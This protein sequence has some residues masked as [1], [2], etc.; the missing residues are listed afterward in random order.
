MR[1]GQ[2]SGN[3]RIIASGD[4]FLFDPWEDLSINIENEEGLQIKVV[5][6]FANDEK[7][8][9]RVETAIVEDSLVMTCYNFD[10]LGT[11]LKRPTHI[12]DVDDKA[13][14]MLFSSQYIGNKDQGTRSV[15]YTIFLEN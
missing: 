10:S 11:G 6:K 14:F 5:M 12:A 13:V 4:T 7:K 15:K 1:V 2:S 9:H 8:E 3:Y